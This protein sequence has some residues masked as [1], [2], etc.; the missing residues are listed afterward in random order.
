MIDDA[1]INE[2]ACSCGIR[3]R[4]TPKGTK[5]M[6]CYFDNISAFAKACY[7]AGQDAQRE[8]DARLCN[9]KH[10]NWRFDDEDDSA[11]GPRECA[12]AIRANK[13]P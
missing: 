7:S 10:Y 3:Y 11:S 1:T 2:L 4:H 13:E 12:S 5:E 6:W 8:S 9:D